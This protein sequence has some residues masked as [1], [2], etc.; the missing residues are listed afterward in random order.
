MGR[1]GED[2]IS[3]FAFLVFFDRLTRKITKARIR[4]KTSMLIEIMAARTD[5][6][7]PWLEE[8]LGAAT[9]LEYSSA[10]T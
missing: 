1:T 6:D 9:A 2:I 3:F 8:V 5:F 10:T 4:R 7:N